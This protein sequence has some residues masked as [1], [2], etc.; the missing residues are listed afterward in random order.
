M[1]LKTVLNSICICWYLDICICI[2]RERERERKNLCKEQKRVK[3]GKDAI[4]VTPKASAFKNPT[5]SQ[6][7]NTLLWV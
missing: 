7:P 5:I 3:E 1:S 6:L 2:Y 4:F